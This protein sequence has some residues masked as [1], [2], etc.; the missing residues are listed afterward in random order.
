MF[1][2]PLNQRTVSLKLKRGEL[3]D[4]MLACSSIESAAVEGG[5]QKWSALHEKLKAILDAFDA[6]QDLKA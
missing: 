1:E 3:C 2:T 6:K 4:L 5:T